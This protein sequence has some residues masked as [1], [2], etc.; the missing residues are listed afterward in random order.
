V[1]TDPFDEFEGIELTEFAGR[2]LDGIRVINRMF[3][4]RLMAAIQNHLSAWSPGDEDPRHPIRHVKSISKECRHNVYRLKYEIHGLTD[5]RWR[6]FFALL[7]HRK[8][9][10]RLVLA[11]VDFVSQDQCYDNPSEKHRIEILKAI[12]EAVARGDTKR[13]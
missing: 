8:P 9:P 4:A 3:F 6:V 12:D 10:V 2:Q 5:R 7:S 1:A 11:V 13:K